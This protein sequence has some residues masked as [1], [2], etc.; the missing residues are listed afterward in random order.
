MYYFLNF[1]HI[2]I[3]KYLWN[4]I[5]AFNETP[6][7]IATR[8]GNTEIVDILLEHPYIEIN[9]KNVLTHNQLSNQNYFLS[10]Y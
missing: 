9:C 1:Y 7:T 4:H 5:Q 10:L 2:Y 8:E 6:L 3:D